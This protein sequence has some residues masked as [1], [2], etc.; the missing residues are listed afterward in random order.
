MPLSFSRPSHHTFLLS[1]MDIPGD[2]APGSLAFLPAPHLP[3]LRHNYKPL[4]KHAT[5][6]CVPP[7]M[8]S[9][10]RDDKRRMS[11]WEIFE[12]VVSKNCRCFICIFQLHETQSLVW[13][14]EKN[15]LLVAC[16]SHTRL[17]SPKALRSTG[18]HQ[19]RHH[20]LVART[21]VYK[22]KLEITR[23]C[24]TSQIPCNIKN[25]DTTPPTKT[26]YTNCI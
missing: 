19:L 25:E 6:L 11:V 24:N 12:I 13:W 1:F 3:V 14:R 10:G 15:V 26:S 2:A 9:P 21:A 18:H 17:K 4:N 8:A 16:L 5:S 7:L 22:D 23:L 20:Q